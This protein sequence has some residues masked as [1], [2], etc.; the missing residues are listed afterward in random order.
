MA[1]RSVTSF[2]ARSVDCFFMISVEGCVLS[3]KRG[4][5]PSGKWGLAPSHNRWQTRHQRVGSVPVPFFHGGLWL[6]AALARTWAVSEGYDHVLAN[7]ATSRPKKGTG[8]VGNV[9]RHCCFTGR[10][11][12]Q[13][14]FSPEPRPKKGTG[15][16][17]N[18][19]HRCCIGRRRSQSPFS[20]SHNCRWTCMIVHSRLEGQSQRLFHLLLIC[21][22]PCSSVVLFP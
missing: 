10:R 13:S 20:G 2:S 11:R 6:V 7:V 21:V 15:T 16:V 1:I 4:L 8:T 5:A 19:N 12:S 22:Y 9:N 18:V 14:P 17:G 3:G